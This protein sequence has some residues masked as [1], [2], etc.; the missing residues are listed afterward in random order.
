MNIVVRGKVVGTQD[1]TE[2]WIVDGMIERLRPANPLG[3]EE[4]GGH[5]HWIAPGLLDIQING[6]AGIDFNSRGFTVEQ[7][8]VAAQGLSRPA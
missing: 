5:H 8:I 7:G 1:L 6:Y 3:F 2:I 4:I